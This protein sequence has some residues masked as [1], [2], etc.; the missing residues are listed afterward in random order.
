[1]EVPYLYHYAK[2]CKVGKGNVLMPDVTPCPEE[3][4]YEFGASKL[5]FT[6]QLQMG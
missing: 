6:N 2:H 4:Y 1:M 5:Q 3:F